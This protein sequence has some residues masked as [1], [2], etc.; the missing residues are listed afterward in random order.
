MLFTTKTLVGLLSS[1]NA[2]DHGT[3]A[4][5]TTEEAPKPTVA[6]PGQPSLLSLPFAMGRKEAHGV[7]STYNHLFSLG[8]KFYE[9]DQDAALSVVRAFQVLQQP[10]PASLLMKHFN[11]RVP[12]M[13]CKHYYSATQIVDSCDDIVSLVTSVENLD[14]VPYMELL[15]PFFLVNYKANGMANKPTEETI[16]TLKQP[17]FISQSACDLANQEQRAMLAANN[18]DSIPNPSNVSGVC[19]SYRH[20]Q[21]GFLAAVTPEGVVTF[22]TPSS[23]NIPSHTGKGPTSHSA[24]PRPYV[25]DYKDGWSKTQYANGTVTFCP[26]NAFPNAPVSKFY[27]DGSSLT[28]TPRGSVIFQLPKQ[29]VPPC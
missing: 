20:L 4:T 10:P 1:N 17:Y 11:N 26:P 29:C 13:V 12:D 22:F 28:I 23:T 18:V 5:N 8:S 14:G 21:D 2:G 19:P 9:T 27:G 3:N 6:L 25:K 7:I 15:K 16:Q 24:S